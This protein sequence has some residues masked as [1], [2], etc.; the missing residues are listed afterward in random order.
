MSDVSAPA[1][2]A[3]PAAPATTAQPAD[4]AAKDA[5][6]TDSTAP[7]GTKSTES[8]ADIEEDAEELAKEEA[9]IEKAIKKA[10]KLKV[11]GKDVDVDEAELIKRA[12]M[13]F[14]ADAKWQ[15]AATI[16]KQ[17][18]GFLTLLQQDPSEALA[19]LGMD[20]DDL[21][22]RHIQRRIEEMKKTPEQ[23]E[24]EKLQKEIEK[25]KKES[26][27]RQKQAR[28]EEIQRLQS[29]F[30]V[31]IENDISSALEDATSGLP[32]SPYVIKRV[33]DLLILAMQKGK[34][35]VRARDVLPMIKEEVRNELRE[36][37]NVV[38]DDMFEEMVGK[39][40]LTKYR[41]GKI[42]K[43]KAPTASASDVKSTGQAEMKANKETKETPRIRAKDFFNKLGSR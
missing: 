20:V 26:E 38:P 5:K 31:E 11:D 30:S 8:D 19:R 43:P 36:M 33:A 24:R 13:G 22:E 28:D 29:K 27:M 7:V 35:D 32:K 18:E 2:S 14:S 37:Y 42:K 4:A 39:D 16:K 17:M 15:E 25:Y 23:L 1:A 9:K 3:A 40:R 6:A 21:A 10:Y 12:Q 41:K 34:K